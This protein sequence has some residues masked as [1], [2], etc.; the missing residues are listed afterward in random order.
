MA[1]GAFCASGDRWVIADGAECS[2]DASKRFSLSRDTKMHHI[3]VTSAH[4]WRKKV[5][6]AMSEY[7]VSITETHNAY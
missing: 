6:A 2:Y 7:R 5:P 1:A 3:S 4:R